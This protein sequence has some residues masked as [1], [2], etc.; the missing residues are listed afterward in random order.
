MW[1]ND[2]WPLE[3]RRRTRPSLGRR[4]ATNNRSVSTRG[5]TC[6]GDVR[7]NECRNFD[8]PRT[9]AP[10]RNLKS[11]SSPYST[12][13]KT[14]ITLTLITL[15]VTLDSNPVSDG[16]TLLAFWIYITLHLHYYFRKRFNYKYFI[17]KIVIWYES[18]SWP[19]AMTLSPNHNQGA[20][21]Q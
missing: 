21:E 18:C 12:L 13:T 11:P 9:L 20:A 16:Q 6:N 1:Q 14:S 2:I 17:Q 19:N 10:P 4:G 5:L 8:P 7:R 3:E 15:T